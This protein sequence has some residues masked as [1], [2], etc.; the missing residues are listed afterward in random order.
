MNL[1]DKDC[2]E[3]RKLESLLKEL[4]SRCI[5]IWEGGEGDLLLEVRDDGGERKAKVKGGST[6]RIK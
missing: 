5:D 6:M 1:N 2:K 4:V 3:I